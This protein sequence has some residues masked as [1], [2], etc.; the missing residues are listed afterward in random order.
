MARTAPRG[1]GRGL[2]AI[3]SVSEGPA[4]ADELRDLPVELIA[5]NP[6]Q[7]RRAFDEASLASLADS[8]AAN[9][10]LQPVLVRPVAGGTY[11]LVAGERRWRAAKLA[12]LERVPALVRE[13]DDAASL[14]LA[15]VENMAREDLN[16]VEEARA[17][18][19]LVEDFGLTKGEVGR[20]VG[21]SRVA[22]SNLIRLLELPDEA[23]EL[24]EAGALTEGH[25]RAILMCK[26]HDA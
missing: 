23:L 12:G 11:E 1:M 13:R 26:D 4:E 18:A 7:P 20:R 22:V 21:K 3:L 9:G 19:M 16:P 5:P 14:E 25:G 10:V 6:N 2:A 17:C 15:L 24:I 8:I